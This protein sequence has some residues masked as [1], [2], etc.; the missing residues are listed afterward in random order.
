MSTVITTTQRARRDYRCGVCLNLILRGELYE[1]TAS[2]PKDDMY[3]TGRW[4]HL[5]AHAPHGV[6][7]MSEMAQA[8][9][10]REA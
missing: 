7:L 10:G 9:P 4:D 5:F 2:T 1:R 6:C 8:Q 3:N